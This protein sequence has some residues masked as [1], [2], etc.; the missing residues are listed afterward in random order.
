MDRLTDSQVRVMDFIRFFW[1]EN[2]YPPTISDIALGL[3]FN[4]N[5]A[6]DHVTNLE[7]KGYLSKKQNSA[8]TI[9]PVDVERH[10]KKYFA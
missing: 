3:E 6:Q 9:V 8:R 1:K 5:A 2:S 4:N 10:I 7:R